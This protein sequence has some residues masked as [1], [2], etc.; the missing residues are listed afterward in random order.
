MLYVEAFVAVL[1]YMWAFV[2][3]FVEIAFVAKFSV[4]CLDVF[5]AI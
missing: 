4:W 1:Y 3:D 5:V 2:A